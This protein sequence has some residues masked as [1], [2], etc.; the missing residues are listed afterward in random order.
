MTTTHTNDPLGFGKFVPGFD[1]LQGLSKGAAQASS[2]SSPASAAFNQWF[3]PT[4]NA[5]DLDKRIG[6]L[7]TVQFW[8]EQNT[9]ALAA[10]IQALEVQKMTLATLKGMNFPMPSAFT[11]TS[12][13][14]NP[15][16]P[17]KRHQ[18]AQPG[19]PAPG[20]QAAA[21]A[22]DPMHMWNALTQQ[23]QNIAATALKDVGTAASQAAAKAATATKS[24]APKTAGTRASARPATKKAAS[25]APARARE[26]HP[27]MQHFPFAHATHPQWHGA[28]ALVLAQLRAQMADGQHASAPNL[29]L[30]YITDNYVDAAQDIL[31]LPRCRTTRHHGLGR[32]RGRWHCRNQC[33]I[34]RRACAGS[35]AAGNTQRPVPRVLRR[36]AVESGV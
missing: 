4:M 8:L 22:V 15:C 29:G 32:H 21:P 11:G 19:N 3:T 18:A 24:A 35:H 17:L 16:A 26:R 27:R 28:A 1:F 2:A 30:L 10:T 34:L 12:A 20:P 23:F 31:E 36:F 33:G 9:R 13:G 5:E 25:H 6:E 14:R 7:K